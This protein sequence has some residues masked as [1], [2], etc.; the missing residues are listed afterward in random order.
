LPVTISI[1]SLATS[2]RSHFIP[3]LI[4]RLRMRGL[5]LWLD[6]HGHKNNKI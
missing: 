3:V 1:I 5:T 6:C 2:V 4:A